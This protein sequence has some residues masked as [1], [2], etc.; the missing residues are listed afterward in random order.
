MT[1]GEDSVFL[2]GE[3]TLVVLSAPGKIMGGG[4]ETILGQTIK[5]KTAL[6]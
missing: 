5:R 6:V 3:Y 1:R 2:K 4:G